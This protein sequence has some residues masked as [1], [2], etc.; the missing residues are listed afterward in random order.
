MIAVFHKIRTFLV[1]LVKSTNDIRLALKI[2]SST[3][4]R[5]SCPEHANQSSIHLAQNIDVATLKMMIQWNS[6]LLRA[7]ILFIQLS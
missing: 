1:L 2:K 5:N 6:E 4:E 3:S 7:R